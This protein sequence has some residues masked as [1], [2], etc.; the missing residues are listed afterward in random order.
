MSNSN[1][2]ADVAKLESQA[3]QQLSD[4]VR[5]LVVDSQPLDVRLEVMSAKSGEAEALYA[6]AA[7]E[8]EK[9]GTPNDA[10][11]GINLLA[12]ALAKELQSKHSDADAMFKRAYTLL[13]KDGELQENVTSIIEL[14]CNAGRVM[15]LDAK[16]DLSEKFDQRAIEVAEALLDDTHPYRAQA[17]YDLA[18]TMDVQGKSEA[19]KLYE[20]SLAIQEN[21]LG[22]SANLAK[23][24]QAYL[25]FENVEAAKR[26]YARA[27]GL[28]ETAVGAD[29]EDL[30][31]LLLTC[32]DLEAQ[33]FENHILERRYFERALRIS[34]KANGLESDTTSG[35]IVKLGMS[36]MMCRDF[37]AA[38]KL[39]ESVLPYREKLLGGNAPQFIAEI[40]CMA[41][42][43]LISGQLEKARELFERIL[44]LNENSQPPNEEGLAEAA[45]HLGATYSQLHRYEEAADLLTKVVPR[46]EK[47]IG[48]DHPL[49]ANMKLLL[50]DCIQASSK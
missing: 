15:S 6:Q 1:Q 39:F 10:A 2:I 24:A 11:L 33:V 41:M 14:L 21:S 42:S 45:L 35:I 26:L 28:R 32:G 23:L 50:A 3:L 40:R 5:A 8:R 34:E 27:L 12:S 48:P 20:K 13:K 49:L 31:P 19:D 38:V 7:A 46:A 29:S 4:A 25:Q 44:V 17:H 47:A 18:V 36:C 30:I 9:G 16:F 43:C 37:V 22:M